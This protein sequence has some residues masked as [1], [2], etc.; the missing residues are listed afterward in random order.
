MEV[1]SGESLAG[2]ME[3]CS[4]KPFYRG[5]IVFRNNNRRL[6]FIQSIKQEA[7][8]GECGFS[9]PPTLWELWFLSKSTILLCTADIQTLRGIRVNEIILD[10]GISED[11]NVF[12]QFLVAYKLSATGGNDKENVTTSCD[13]ALDTFLDS[14]KIID[15]L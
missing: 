1:L 5:A 11:E 8:R 2:M 13:N 9:I 14:F 10:E 4:Q 3:R 12:A 7:K 6:E 15:G